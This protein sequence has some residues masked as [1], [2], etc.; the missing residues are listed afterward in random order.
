M[1][2]FPDA[3]LPQIRQTLAIKCIQIA[4]KLQSLSE[5]GIHYL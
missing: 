4:S 5:E 1:G 2:T 3:N